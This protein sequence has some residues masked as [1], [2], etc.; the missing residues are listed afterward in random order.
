MKIRILCVGKQ[1]Q[2][3]LR[4]GSELYLK[5]INR[6]FPCS[7]DELR[8][9]KGGKKPDRARLCRLEGEQLLKR[10]PDSAYVIA[11]DE[12]GRQI[13]SVELSR[14]LENFMLESRDQVIFIIGGPYGLSDAVRQR[15]NRI[16]SLSAMTFTHQMVRLFL[17]EQIYRATTILR[18]EPYHHM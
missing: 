6:V 11:L 7:I 18:N 5:R 14:T 4:E 1:S 8:E 12:R 10:I 13:D 2:S 16:L 15:S 3:W 17:L 9:E